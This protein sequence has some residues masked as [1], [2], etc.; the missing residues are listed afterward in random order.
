MVR[1]DIPHHKHGGKSRIINEWPF[2]ETTVGV[3]GPEIMS[4]DV[5]ATTENQ[6]APYGVTGAD[7]NILGVN[8]FGNEFDAYY[9]QTPTA[10]PVTGRNLVS[11]Q[12][13]GEAYV[14]IANDN[15]AAIAFGKA[16]QA[17]TDS[18]TVETVVTQTVTAV[19]LAAFT[20]RSDT[21][22]FVGAGWRTYQAEEM[23]C[24][25]KAMEYKAIN[26]DSDAFI[27]VQITTLRPYIVV[28]TS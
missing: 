4:V 14:R 11:I 22:A 6:C 7:I 13:C 15:S 18:Q 1:Y 23:K 19:D 20:A 21:Y 17:E 8:L 2:A 24:L 16:V 26:T 12:D 10:T 25:G 9:A 28:P 5:S 3:W 27:A